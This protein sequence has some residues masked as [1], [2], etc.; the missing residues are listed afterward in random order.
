MFSPY[1]NDYSGDYKTDLNFKSSHLDDPQAQACLH[2]EDL[3][4][5]LPSFA[6]ERLMNSTKHCKILNIRLHFEFNL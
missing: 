3:L 2:I 5:H 6:L 1:L 4:R